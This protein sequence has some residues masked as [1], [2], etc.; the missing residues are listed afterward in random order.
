MQLTASHALKYERVG[1]VGWAVGWERGAS[2]VHLD[3][4]PELEIAAQHSLVRAQASPFPLHPKL[5]PHVTARCT[6]WNSCG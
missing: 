2:V 6:G 4:E 5:F 3:M 1:G